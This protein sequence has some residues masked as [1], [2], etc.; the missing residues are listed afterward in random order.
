MKKQ[1][2]TAY[3]FSVDRC[4]IGFDIC[5][6]FCHIPMKLA[7]TCQ[8]LKNAISFFKHT[9]KFI[10]AIP[11]NSFDNIIYFAD[12]SSP[13]VISNSGKL[14]FIIR[15]ESI[16]L[17]KQPIILMSSAQKFSLLYMLKIMLTPIPLFSV[18][19]IVLYNSQANNCNNE[20]KTSTWWVIKLTK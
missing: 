12:C 2:F 11:F 18:N 6:L 14:S 13:S 9:L 17:W 4:K 3:H 5:N 1:S 19:I 7:K 8:L 16:M 15:L 20:C 10:G